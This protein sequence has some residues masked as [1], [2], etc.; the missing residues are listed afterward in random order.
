M[1]VC[2][3]GQDMKVQQTIDNFCRIIGFHKA[4]QDL[5]LAALLPARRDR[6]WCVLYSP[7][8]EKFEIPKLPTL[9]I[10]PTIADLLPE[11]PQLSHS[12]I[13]Q[14]ELDRYET[15]KFEMYGGLMNRVIDPEGQLPTALHGWANQLTACP[16][17]CRMFPMSESRLRE[18]GL[19]GALAILPGFF[20]T[21][22]WILPKTRH[23]HPIEIAI[24]HGMPCDGKWGSDM[25][26]AICGLGQL[27]SPIH[28]VWVGAHFR[29]VLDSL[30][31]KPVLSPVA[32]LANH[33]QVLFASMTSQVPAIT[34]H[35]RFLNYVDK[36]W[37]VLRA[38]CQA[39]SPLPA[40]PCVDE[41]DQEPSTS[42]RSGRKDL[43]KVK[44]AVKQPA[45]K[46][47]ELEKSNKQPA[48]KSQELE[49]KNKQPAPKS[50]ELVKI[51][52]QPAEEAQGLHTE[53]G[54]H[55]PPIPVQ[56]KPALPPGTAGPSHGVHDHLPVVP[57][58]WMN[59]ATKPST[60]VFP[61]QAVPCY[62]DP[63]RSASPAPPCATPSE[64]R[65]GPSHVLETGH[66]KSEEGATP[67]VA[68]QT[69]VLALPTHGGIPAFANSATVAQA[70][71][72]ITEPVTFTDKPCDA[73]D[74]DSPSS[75][76]QDMVSAA[77]AYER[78][79][80]ELTGTNTPTEAVSTE[81][82]HEAPV[83]RSVDEVDSHFVQIIHF[84]DDLP[85]VIKVDKKAT[86]ASITVATASLGTMQQHIRT[87]DAVGCLISQHAV[88]EP[89]QQIFLREMASMP[90]HEAEIPE[91]PAR[92]QSLDKR[93]RLSILLQQEG[94]V[95]HD[96]MQMYLGTIQQTGFATAQPPL[97]M[98]RSTE[99][100]ELVSLLTA[101]GKQ[102]VQHLSSCTCVIS[103]LL[104]EQHWMPVFFLSGPMGVRVA[105][106]YEGESWIQIAIQ[107]EAVHRTIT[108]V[109]H[110]HAFPNDCGFQC[111]AWLT[112]LVHA[113]AWPTDMSTV[114]DF[115][116]SEALTW[117]S[118]F[119]HMIL[120]QGLADLPM[121]P[122]DIRF[123]G[124]GKFDVNQSL[125]QLLLEKGVH[126][127]QVQHR[128]D[129]VLTQLGRSRV[130]Q[131]LRGWRDLKSAANNAQPKLQL[132]LSSE[133]SDVIRARTDDPTPFGHKKT[134]Q[135]QSRPHETSKGLHVCPGDVSV[136]DGI[137]KDSEDHV[138]SQICKTDIGPQARGVVVVDAAEAQARMAQPVSAHGLALVLVDKPHTALHGVGDEIRFPVKCKATDEPMLISARL[139]QLGAKHIMRN[140]VQ[141]PPKIDEVDTFVV[142]CLAYRDELDVDWAAF[143][144]Q[145]VKQ[146]I[147]LHPELQLPDMILDCWDRQFLGMKLTRTKPSDAAIYTVSFRITGTQEA[148]I[149]ALSGKLGVYFEPRSEDGRAH[150]GAYRV[151]WLNKIERA[152]AQV[153]H[154]STK[155]WS[156]LVR[157]GARFGLR[158]QAAQAQ[159]VHTF[160]KP[161]VPFVDNASLRTF[162]GGPF[163]YGATRPALAKIFTAWGWEARPVQP[164]GK[165]LEG[166]GM[167]WEIQA[168]G[169]PPFGVYQ[170]EHSDVLLTEVEPKTKRT[171][172]QG[173]T[174]QGSAKTIAA[175]KAKQP[176]NAGQDPWQ[177]GTPDPW[178]NYE[179]PS[180]V[181]KP[182]LPNM[183]AVASA[184]E[185]KVLEKVTPQL[186]SKLSEDSEMA[187][188][189]KIGEL[190]SRLSKLEKDVKTQ[191][192]HQAKHNTDI[193]QQVNQVQQQV[194]RQGQDIQKHFDVK[195]QEQLAQI[196]SL[197]K[198]KQARH[199]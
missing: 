16:C 50:Q 149:L 195:L 128:A 104:V 89:F 8:F 190:E 53:A 132:V 134:K 55:V 150:S 124:V 173:I 69:K 143:S 83:S 97:V 24:L 82:D 47:Q 181:Q 164:R 67:A 60:Q 57:T 31:E 131:L 198:T 166:K 26:L 32:V 123:G 170:M 41:V 27:A 158:V 46:P 43:S 106:T 34:A 5:S 160:H 98:P 138:V 39:D 61:C 76:T 184:I 3:A 28:S 140:Q 38:H 165:S 20:E 107:H 148:T 186:Q 172:D 139:I 177:A 84:G 175:L 45:T 179:G 176:T 163:P 112:Q 168:G 71:T 159:E 81:S 152:Q 188:V 74:V 22:S 25:K 135:K 146:I 191:H 66:P 119:H 117:R 72:Y 121:R 96:E 114:R 103:A 193:K 11:I 23:L 197:L 116:S 157:S 187:D 93:T 151:I 180:K 130:A 86:A 13:S 189:S 92:L 109:A 4:T 15:G 174:V 113:E 127:E 42:Q 62:A 91:V 30:L 64:K 51:T 49:K 102:C 85:Q 87:Q 125:V 122:W 99:D 199:E 79:A 136:P 88:T 167:L 37:V 178:A 95:A 194:E 105:T 156:C 169:G 118:T 19:F 35:A 94:W 80:A 111:V 145:P 142:K 40:I 147:Q 182:T 33:F 192:Q 101:W 137:F 18:K 73:N 54:P 7:V 100:D 56:A 44:K 70:S 185:R 29:V 68:A 162:I 141:T 21:S 115:T 2:Q 78:Q 161:N 155:P 10:A 12:D 154:Q 183:D 129:T 108:R 48:S 120:T 6:W 59:E 110:P 126:Q 75:F 171:M 1:C 52:K 133:L 144:S 65:C 196:E 14:L 77:L 90:L 36:V 153:A 9:P 63:P 58:S 17:S